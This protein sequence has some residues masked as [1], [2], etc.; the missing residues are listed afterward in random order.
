MADDSN[1]SIEPA[2]FNVSATDCLKP[3]SSA[4]D[5]AKRVV[6]YGNFLNALE[7]MIEFFNRE[8][9]S[10]IILQGNFGTGKKTLLKEALRMSKKTVYI[11]INPYHIT[12]DLSALKH[13]ARELGLNLR[14]SLQQVMEDIEERSSKIAKK[15]VIVLP[16]FEQF[17]RLKQS[18]LYCLTN[19]I[20]HTNNI[21][22]IG[23]TVRFDATEHLEKRVRSRLNASFYELKHP[24]SNKDEY[25][26]FASLILG[27]C[28]L[29]KSIQTQ[30]IQLYIQE[31]SI[32]ALKSFLI[33]ACSWNKKGS[34]SIKPRTIST[35]D[36]LSV[37]NRFTWLTIPQQEL[38]KIAIS[39]CNDNDCCSFTLRALLSYS[40]KR[41]YKID[42]E[43]PQAFKD[44]NLLASISVFVRAK[45][46]QFISEDTEF[47]LGGSPIEIKGIIEANPDLHRLRTD[48]L[49]KKWRI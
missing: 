31:R 26:Q 18:L 4:E 2:R 19:L 16:H 17:C 1:C 3:P 41:D 32:R 12:D 15:I 46:S 36:P 25:L 43:S 28:N 14:P 37:H 24:Y 34:L 35:S 38:F 6:H 30:L 27:Q 20:Q 44:V 9:S 42:I 22:V 40:S 11:Q 8:I 47:T 10:S 48:P 49:W 45:H 23:T 39:Y 5:I 21:G 29:S 7:Y 33:Q 13:I